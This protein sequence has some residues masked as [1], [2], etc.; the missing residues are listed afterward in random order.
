VL[1]RIGQVEN[2]NN[3]PTFLFAEIGNNHN[4]NITL[5]KQ[6][7]DLAAESGANCAKFQ[8]RD[9]AHFFRYL[10]MLL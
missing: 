6:L 2:G 8:L 1:I 10:I 3:P 5:L 7:I 9:F 4:K